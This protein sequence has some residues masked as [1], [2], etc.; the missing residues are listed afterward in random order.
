MTIASL[1]QLSVTRASNTDL[2]GINI[3]GS[4]LVS[5]ADD[6]DR[7]LG[8]QIAEW[9]AE[10]SYPTVGGSADVLT[11]TP[12]TALAALANNVVYTGKIATT[13]ATTTPTMNV[14]ALGAKVIRKISA[15][16]TDVALAVG[17][18]PAGWPAAWVYSTAANSAGG[19]WILINPASVPS[20]AFSDSTFRVQD[21]GDATKQ[22]AFEVSGITTGTTRTVTQPDASG[23]MA[24]DGAGQ[25]TVASATSTLIGASATREII[26]SGTTTITSFD[27]VAAG[28]VREGYF[29]GAL[30]LTHSGTALILPGSANIT[31]AANDRFRFLSLGSGNWICVN[32]TKA[33]GT[34]VVASA[35]GQ[36]IPS[37]STY[38]VG[39][40]L[41]VINATGGSIANGS[42]GA[43]SGLQSAITSS[44]ALAG[45]GAALSGTWK[46]V[47][48]ATIANNVFG[49]FVR[50]V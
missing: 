14:S 25:T 33:D 50:T 32:Y 46:N 36:P 49:Y 47:S 11:L 21:N 9:L 34:A 37:S 18:Q 44:G 41:F 28:T 40:L 10:M 26:I 20:G 8:G 24:L 3:T 4:G 42:T 29:S 15:A 31:T 43:G 22:L 30:T 27:T 2:G 12:T 48:G 19:A 45:S 6:F 13:N 16:G 38:A 7:E 39:T 17:D 23:V 1:R 35:A 5:T